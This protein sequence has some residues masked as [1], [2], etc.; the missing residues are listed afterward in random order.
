MGREHR[1]AHPRPFATS[2]SK[3]EIALFQIANQFDLRHRGA[4]Q[5]DDYAEAYLDWIFWWYLVVCRINSDLS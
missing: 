2:T 3:D 5:R 1:R 4:D